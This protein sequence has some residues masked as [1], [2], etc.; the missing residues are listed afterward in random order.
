MPAGDH[1]APSVVPFS[2]GRPREQRLQSRPAPRTRRAYRFAFPDASFDYIY[3]GSVFT[4]MPVEEVEQ[5][6]REIARLLA[7]GGTCIASF[8]LLDAD[9]RAASPAVPASCRSATRMRPDAT[10]CTTRRCRSGNRDRRGMDSGVYAREGLTIG[11]V[12]RGRWWD[13]VAHDRTSSRRGSCRTAVSRTDGIVARL[14]P[15]PAVSAFAGRGFS[16]AASVR[17]AGQQHAGIAD[18][19]SGR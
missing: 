2:S 15:R 18:A 17:I 4:H 13:G 19:R 9:S 3:L 11:D 14:K 7:P 12:R 10:A 6:V 16:P 8:F 5:Y 1:A